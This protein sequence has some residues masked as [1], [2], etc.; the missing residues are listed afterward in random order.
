MNE[1]SFVPP[2]CLA[3]AKSLAI[4]EVLTRG[5][6]CLRLVPDVVVSELLVQILFCADPPLTVSRIQE[7]S[8][9]CLKDR[10]V[11]SI[12]VRILSVYDALPNLLSPAAVLPLAQADVVCKAHHIAVASQ[13]CKKQAMADR[14]VSTVVR[15]ED[16]IDR[17]LQM[18]QKKTS[19]TTA[20]RPLVGD[21]RNAGP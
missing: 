18:V 2:H 1:I 12:F 19:Q 11:A 3:M 20:V 10:V 9:V 13:A 4:T 21:D 8:G 14:V 5:Q 16:P 15:V 6:S 17:Q 7:E